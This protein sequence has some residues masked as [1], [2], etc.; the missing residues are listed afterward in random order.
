M[1]TVDRAADELCTN[2]V[3]SCGITQGRVVSW[4]D[5]MAFGTQ[6]GFN[7]V[8]HIARATWNNG[9]DS[10]MTLLSTAGRPPYTRLVESGYRII[11]DKTRYRAWSHFLELQKNQWLT[12]QEL[13]ELRWARL[14]RLLDYA[15]EAV[16]FYRSLW[17]ECGID[18]RKFD[19][20]ENFS[21]LPI[22]DKEIL[23]RAQHEQRFPSASGKKYDVAYTSG[24]TGSRFKIMF[25]LET[26]QKKYAS[27]LRQM[28]ATGWRLGFKSATLHYSGHSQ[29]RGKYTGRPDDR[30]P[31]MGIREVA[32]MLAH[33]RK[34]LIPYHAALIS[35]D[36]V[37][38]SWYNALTV[39]KPYLFETLDYNLPLLKDFIERRNLPP[40]DIPKVVVLGTYSARRRNELQNFFSTE[41][42]NRYSPHEMEGLAFS[43][44]VHR[45]MHIAS[46]CYH[47]EFVDPS[48][49]LV[50]C[51]EM[52][53]IIV[54][55]MDNYLMPL[56]RYRVGDVG[57]AIEEPCTCGRA[58]PLMGDLD[59][60]TRDC[61]TDAK[62]ARI[63][64]SKIA[65]VLHDEPDVV[66]FQVTQ[67]EA[68]QITANIIVRSPRAAV[69]LCSNIQLRL[70][71]L[72]GEGLPLKVKVVDN[73]SLEANGKFCFVKRSK[74]TGRKH[75]IP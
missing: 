24:T 14:K 41:V 27:H 1:F 40:V 72:V 30:E 47:I 42:F 32:L 26:Y 49:R 51:G 10:E 9:S 50:D 33:R 57:Y 43:C 35:D 20:I 3:I 70:A 21:E 8:H 5:G 71:N 68:L 13:E 44:N 48:D 7:C 39:Y 19:S 37:L 38:L 53:E 12:K 4:R 29:F 18:P 23:T 28:Y 52:G 25:T 56:I 60:R 59:G 17:Q 16:P 15:Y 55:D 74:V 34:N 46:D 58:M 73:L 61:F 36:E 63:A 45:G 31:F 75:D 67:D 11:A 6:I 64:P 54:T 22:V 62:G 65:A 2:S 66:L 69:D